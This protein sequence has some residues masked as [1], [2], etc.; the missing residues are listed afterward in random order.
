MAKGNI[1]WSQATGKLGDMV[2]SINKGQVIQRAY[3]KQVRNPR[4]RGQMMQRARFA[5]AVKFYRNAYENFFQFAY[6]DKKPNESDYN[7]FMRHNT[8]SISSVLKL[9][10]VRG[11]F[12]ALGQPWMIT[13]GS[14]PADPYVIDFGTGIPSLEIPNIAPGATTIGELSQGL[15]DDYY[16]VNGDIVTIV[17]VRSSVSSINEVEVPARPVWDIKQFIV[18]NADATP[19]SELGSYLSATDHGLNLDKAVQTSATWYGVVF[20]RKSSNGLR[21]TDSYLYGNAVVISMWHAANDPAWIAEAL[22]TWDVSDEAILEGALAMESS[23]E[24]VITSAN[25]SQVDQIQSGATY[26]FNVVGANLQDLTAASFTS[27]NP[28]LVVTAFVASA[29]GKSA[30][31]T[32]RAN[33]LINSANIS[34]NGRVIFKVVAGNVTLI[35]NAN[36]SSAAGGFDITI[37]GETNEMQPG[38]AYEYPAGKQVT[39]TARPKEGFEF[40]HWD[41]SPSDTEAVRQL[42]L[43]A[44]TTITGY[45]AEM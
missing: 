5:N 6:E 3:Q 11:N 42:T 12:P 21:V 8:N 23:T 29:D 27:N 7:A 30:T 39:V 35:A 40:V 2:I 1:F 41:D 22:A 17:V 13:S 31:I 14:M 26:Q 37:D 43:N 15:M 4:T 18:N 44:N 38:Q 32:L 10:Q 16:L 20:S 34:Y 33:E 25:P 9:A 24:P 28:A 36:P 19:I 45:F